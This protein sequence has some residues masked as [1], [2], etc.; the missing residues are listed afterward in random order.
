MCAAAGPPCTCAT[1]TR[2]SPTVWSTPSSHKKA[3]C[4]AHSRA[5]GSLWWRNEMKN[6][7]LICAPLLLAACANLGCTAPSP[8]G[9]VDDKLKAAVA[10]KLSQAF[11]TFE[12][13]EI[14]KSEVPGVYEV[15]TR[16]R[17]VY[18]A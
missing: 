9:D 2:K 17:I 14:R 3:S 1:H 5:S 13:D 12:Y 6:F 7:G 8:S 4:P 15:Y 18:F 11:H 10:E 16:G